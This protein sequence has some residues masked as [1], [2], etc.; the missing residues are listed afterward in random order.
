MK[1]KTLSVMVVFISLFLIGCQKVN[2]TV[3]DNNGETNTIWVDTELTD[4]QSGETFH[5]SDFKGQKILLES[6]AVWCPTCTQQ[7]KEIK[8]LHQELGDTFVSISLDTDPNEDVTIIQEHIDRNGF[9]WHYAI[10]PR[11]LTQSLIDEFGIGVVNAPSA[12]VVL[13]CEDQSTHYLGR[14][15]KLV[16]ELKEELEVNC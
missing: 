9:D 10:S 7:Q 1:V 12:P 14:G 8:K 15:L 5:I 11:E 4:V 3:Q 6:F 13:I 16:D 2:P